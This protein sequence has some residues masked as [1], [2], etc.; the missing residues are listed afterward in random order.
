MTSVTTAAVGLYLLLQQ[1]RGA[2]EY[3]HDRQELRV[4]THA[5]LMRR[6]HRVPVEHV[7]GLTV[8]R[9][10]L[11]ETQDGPPVQEYELRL[12]R[13]SGGPVRLLRST[14]IARLEPARAAVSE[15]LLDHR[16]LGGA[17]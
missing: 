5:V 1:R 17:G 14:D 15:F 2:I 13:A 6:T 4:T 11:R 7:V 8:D 12:L 9:L 10:P 3:V 16:L